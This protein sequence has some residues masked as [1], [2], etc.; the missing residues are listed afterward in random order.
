MNTAKITEKQEVVCEIDEMSQVILF[1]L[2]SIT[3][4]T[5]NIGGDKAGYDANKVGKNETEVFVPLFG[6]L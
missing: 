1:H 3:G 2:R 4:N 5:Y 6:E